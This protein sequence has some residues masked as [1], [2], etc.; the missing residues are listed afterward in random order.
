MLMVMACRGCT[1]MGVASDELS[2]D[3]GLRGVA[4]DDELVPVLKDDNTY[5]NQ[6]RYV[7]LSL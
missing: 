1:M 7:T 6:H 5:Q 3:S 2:N 4:S